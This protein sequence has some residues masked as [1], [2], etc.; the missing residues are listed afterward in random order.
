MLPGGAG[1]RARQ[2]LDAYCASRGWPASAFH[3]APEGRTNVVFLG[4]SLGAVVS[5]APWGVGT[6]AVGARLRLAASIADRAPFVQPLPDVGQ[7][8][9]TEHGIVSVWQFV[10]TVP[11]RDF[12]AIGATVARFHGI[13]AT[14]LD[15][16]T[17]PLRPARV[18]RDA[19][20]WIETLGGRGRL[21]PADVRTLTEVDRR[22]VSALGVPDPTPTGLLHGDLYWP[23][24]LVTSGGAVLC[25]VDELGLGSPEYDV[26]YLLDPDRRPLATANVHAFASGYGTS[27]PEPGLRR[28]LVQRSHLTFTLRLAERSSSARGRYW[29]DQWMT[30]WRRVAAGTD[31]AITPPRDHS[32]AAQLATAVRGA[33]E[34]RA[35]GRA[36]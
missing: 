27:V 14:T 2:A 36:G 23:N 5:V 17:S 30:G 24:V 12:E 9:A 13:D 25:D 6:D 28:L 1:H 21:R 34:R 18:M 19:A 22:L 4:P 26:A 10:P 33:L 3:R 11:V 7:P 35:V 32:R 20:A 29:V 31:T 16:G 8:V 15:T